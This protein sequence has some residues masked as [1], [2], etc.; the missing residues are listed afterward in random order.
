MQVTLRLNLNTEAI[1]FRLGELN[2]GPRLGLFPVQLEILTTTTFVEELGCN[3]EPWIPDIPFCP[4]PEPKAWRIAMI[5]RRLRG[6][7]EPEERE[8][9][10]EMISRRGR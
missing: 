4:P 5:P 3:D 9:E 2:H 7:D 6:G 10:R 8:R 1:C